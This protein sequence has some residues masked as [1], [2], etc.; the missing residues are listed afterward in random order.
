MSQ[1]ED[2]M[3][4]ERLERALLSEEQLDALKADEQSPH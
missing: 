2:G 4:C 1:S 3:E